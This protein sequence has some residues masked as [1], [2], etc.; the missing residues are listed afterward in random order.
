MNKL[1]VLFLALILSTCFTISGFADEVTSLIKEALKQ[2]KNGDY[3]ESTNN[4]E[5][6]SQLIRQKK[7]D[8]LLF[9][10]PQPLDG[11]RSEDEANQADGTAMLI[12]GTTVQRSYYKGSSVITI[13]IIAD[14]PF[15]Q[16]IM[17][18][19]NIPL[20]ATAS[21]GKLEIIKGQKAIVTYKPKDKQGEIK[22]IVAGR[23]LITLNGTNVSKGD[24]IAYA[25]TVDYKKIATYY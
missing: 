20:I 10:L 15:L 21:G 19:F 8:K 12:G 14:S 9:S 17:S 2:Y 18:L 11:W 6:A 1:K 22:I 3:V 4:L 13:G 16:S 23:I 25:N 24:I 7:Q 5:Y